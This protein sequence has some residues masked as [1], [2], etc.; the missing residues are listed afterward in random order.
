[1]SAF[2]EDLERGAVLSL[3]LPDCRSM[4]RVCGHGLGG[5][6]SPDARRAL[7]FPYRPPPPAHI[8]RSR[9]WKPVLGACT[10]SRRLGPGPPANVWTMPGGTATSEPAPRRSSLVVV[11][12]RR[13]AL[14]HVERVDVVVVHVRIRAFE[15][16]VELELDE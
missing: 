8:S 5:V 10:L 3:A 1:M 15:A 7:V 4:Q 14:E 9:S 11:H 6:Y 13:F 2:H 12:E 16:R